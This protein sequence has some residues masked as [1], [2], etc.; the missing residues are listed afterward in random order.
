MCWQQKTSTQAKKL[1]PSN[2]G[3]ESAMETHLCSSPQRSWHHKAIY[4][5]GPSNT[6]AQRTSEG[7]KVKNLVFPAMNMKE[8]FTSLQ[9]MQLTH[10]NA[11][12]RNSKISYLRS[13]NQLD[14]DTP[15]SNIPYDVR[16]ESEYNACTGF[17][18]AKFH[19][20]VSA[21]NFE[22]FVGLR[23]H[24]QFQFNLLRASNTV[25]RR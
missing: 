6:C 7:L 14:L 20:K 22:Y 19:Q 8:G 15:A 9:Y 23:I 1:F 16:Q 4:Y 3:P 10:S 25:A 5:Q 13:L 2:L 21:R 17:D 11:Q 18:F 12:R 24:I